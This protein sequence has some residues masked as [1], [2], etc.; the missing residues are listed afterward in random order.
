ML[1]F[2]DYLYYRAC[3]FYRKNDKE[4]PAFAFSGI[5][6]VSATQGLNIMSL[7]FSFY[8]IIHK[9]FH[10]G[11]LEA[12]ALAIILLTFNI[13]R[14]NRIGYGLLNDR[15]KN[16]DEKIKNKKKSFVIVYIVLS[17]TFFLG[18]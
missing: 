6:L 5:A 12:I 17:F 18:R 3:E 16:E 15:W 11:K 2:F 8:L 14:Y 13:I 1:Q 9:T 7:L 10:F 4:D